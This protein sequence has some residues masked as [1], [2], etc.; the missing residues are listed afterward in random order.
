MILPPGSTIGILGGGQL[1]RMLALAAARLGFDTHIYTDEADS[2]AARV[3]AFETLAAY[4]DSAALRAFAA[5]TDVITCE[6]ENVPAQT[7]ASLTAA[8]AIVRPNASAF[9]IAQDR[10]A[11]KNFFRAHGVATT[12]FA[13]IDTPDD[14]RAALGA[15][16]APAILKTRRLG[17]DG[18]GQA[19]I[20][21][22]TDA[23]AA[24]AA[25]QGAPAILEALTPF[26]AEASVLLARGTDGAVAVF[27]V[28]ENRHNDG[29]LI[30]TR[31]PAR[32]ALETQARLRL[33]ALRIAHALDYVGV[34]CVEFFVLADGRALA[35]EMA[36]RVHNSGHWTEDVCLCG[37][38]EQHVRAIAGWPLGQTARMADVEMLNL[39]GQDAADWRSYFDSPTLRLHLYGK[40]DARVG[41][42]MGH[43]TRIVTP[44]LSN[45]DKTTQS[46]A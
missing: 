44:A 38:F 30:E 37:Q 20:T 8:G 42:K 13:Q 41:R 26:T 2:P 16:G 31:I 9:A 27:D 22:A 33:S 29:I 32:L 6:F 3:A 23:E 11:E 5:N 4:D 36:P 10:V 7:L 46:L 21:H 28:C 19:R 14:L 43:A 45:A 25:I 15:L 17:Y 40:R 1:G 18:K 24:F 35:N 34:L 12:D 39:L